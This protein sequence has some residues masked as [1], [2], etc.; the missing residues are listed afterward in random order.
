[1]DSKVA[2]V[3]NHWTIWGCVGNN[4]THRSTQG[5]ERNHDRFLWSLDT[6]KGHR[7]SFTKAAPPAQAEP[8]YEAFSAELEALGVPVVRG[9]FGAR[10]TVE[11]VNDGPVTI[12]LDVA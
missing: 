5:H 11:I 12:V 7:P 2:E 8:L 3:W 9:V 6:S 4:S 10:M 1:V